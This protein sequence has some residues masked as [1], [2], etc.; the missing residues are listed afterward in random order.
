MQTPSCSGYWTCLT[1]FPL[2]DYQIRMSLLQSSSQSLPPIQNQSHSSSSSCIPK[3][4]EIIKQVQLYPVFSGS[5]HPNDSFHKSMTL[6]GCKVMSSWCAEIMIFL[7]LWFFLS[8]AILDCLIIPL[9][10][11]LEEWKKTTVTLDKDHAKGKRTDFFTCFSK[12]Y[13]ATSCW[14]ATFFWWE[15]DIKFVMK[16]GHGSF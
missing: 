1:Y 16:L 7:F 14:L 13:Q 2:H 8:S 6:S 10:E 12:Q 9:Q 3:W 15:V 4:L 11:K 5:Y